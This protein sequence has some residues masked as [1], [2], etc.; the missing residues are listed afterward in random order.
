MDLGGRALGR[1][2][3]EGPAE[4]GAQSE[5]QPGVQADRGLPGEPVEASEELGNPMGVSMVATGAYI[6]ATG[7]V[8]LDSAIAAM[9]ESL[10]AYRRQHAEGDRNTK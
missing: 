10:P 1:R 9:E 5:A 2:E 3:G 6:A 8:G 7:L 4:I